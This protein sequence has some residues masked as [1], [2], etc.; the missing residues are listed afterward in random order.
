MIF[1]WDERKN[2]RND[3][4]HRIRF[5]LA[6]LAF[7]DPWALIR[8]DELYV[9]EERWITLGAVGPL[10]VLVV[11]HTTWEQEDEEIIRIISAREANPS[12]RAVYEN[13]RKATQG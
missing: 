4:K 1:E 7:D 8:R 11:V 3:Q 5:E 12:E 10:L 13:A 6:A 9:H 2:R